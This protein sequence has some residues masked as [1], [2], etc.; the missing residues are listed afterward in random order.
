[1]PTL[2]RSPESRM[3]LLAEAVQR[4]RGKR[5]GASGSGNSAPLKRLRALCCESVADHGRTTARLLQT[6][7]VA[8][9]GSHE[10]Q[11]QHQQLFPPGAN[12]LSDLF[13]WPL[14]VCA[15]IR[16]SPR[17]KANWMRN[18]ANGITIYSDHSGCGSGEEGLRD[19]I[20]AS[21]APGPSWSPLLYSAVD[22]CESAQEALTATSSAKHLFYKV[23]SQIPDKEMKK[24]QCFIPDKKDSAD[25]CEKKLEKLASALEKKQQQLYPADRTSFCMWAMKPVPVRAAKPSGSMDVLISGTECQEWSAM[26]KSARKTCAAN[27]A[28]FLFWVHQIRAQPYDVVLHEN[29]MRFQPLVLMQHLG[30]LQHGTHGTIFAKG[31]IGHISQKHITHSATC[32]SLA[33]LF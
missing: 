18:L 26:N 13:M 1:M 14:K 10:Q 31:H 17:L 11:R 12:T 22:P 32:F 8:A 16:A 20:C 6:G 9:Q 15:K 24:L 23:E 19:V 7:P 21:D 27:F 30:D 28:T 5:Q 33:D 29:V 3:G 25:H 4:G 2:P